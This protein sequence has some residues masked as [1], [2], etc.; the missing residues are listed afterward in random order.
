MKAVRGDDELNQL[1]GGCAAF[2]S[3]RVKDITKAVTW[4][5]APKKVEEEE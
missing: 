2:V 4:K 5:P 1:M 3:D